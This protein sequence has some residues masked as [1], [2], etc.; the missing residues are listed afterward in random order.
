MRLY[1]TSTAVPL[2]VNSLVLYH[3][4][5]ISQI[6][7]K[8]SGFHLESL[9]NSYFIFFNVQIKISRKNITSYFKFYYYTFRTEC[10]AQFGL[11]EGWQ[12]L[13][14]KKS[15]SLKEVN[16]HLMKIKRANFPSVKSLMSTEGGKK[17][18]QQILSATKELINYFHNILKATLGYKKCQQPVSN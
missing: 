17:G 12:I 15:S 1:T 9:W 3:S 5:V 14:L 8:F 7:L 2:H 10:I 6:Y 16:I 4:P 11:E 18:R 13:I